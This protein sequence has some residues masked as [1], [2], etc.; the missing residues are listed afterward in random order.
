MNDVLINHYSE[1]RFLK[2]NIDRKLPWV[3]HIDKL[4]NGP[5]VIK[6]CLK[7]LTQDTV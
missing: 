4:G 6:S 7:V 3:K 1:A 2:V 5:A